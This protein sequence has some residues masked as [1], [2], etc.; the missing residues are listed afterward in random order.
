MAIYSPKRKLMKVLNVQ[1]VRH[2]T[3]ALYD[4]M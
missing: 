3:E 2:Y 1:I 4:P